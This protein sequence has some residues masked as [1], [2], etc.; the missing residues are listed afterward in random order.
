MRPHG[1][2]AITCGKC[3]WSPMDLRDTVT[4]LACPECGMRL[5]IDF[6]RTL[7]VAAV[8]QDI[9]KWIRGKTC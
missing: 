7:E 1:I 8:R 3:G 9:G 4:A 5:E 6:G 2:W